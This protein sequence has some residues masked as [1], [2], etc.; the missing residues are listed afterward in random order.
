MGSLQHI[1]QFGIEGL[2]L[3][4]SAYRDQRD[5]PD[6][7]RR[8]M[9]LIT[10]VGL[11]VGVAALIGDI[12]EYM[13]QPSTE[14]II[15]TIYTD[16]QAMPWYINLSRSDPNFPA[17]FEA[18]FQQITQGITFLN[19]GGLMGSL[20]GIVTTP[21]TMLIIWLLFSSVA[22]LMAHTLGG[23]ATFKQTMACTALASGCNLLGVVQ[24]VPFA[25]V[26]GTLL[27]ALVASYVAVREAHN[28]RPWP[29][30]WAT[31]FGPLLL[32]SFILI[33][34]CIGFFLLLNAATTTP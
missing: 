3:N 2:L 28:L 10:F 8:G 29:A 30:F 22:H 27:L 19:A 7:L 23:Q 15:E 13:T 1:V 9:I 12:G 14:V 34:G 31:M 21:L 16:L 24:V 5:A 33:L 6:G 25:Q 20:T 11:I 18:N 26:A 4:P 17:T 32:V